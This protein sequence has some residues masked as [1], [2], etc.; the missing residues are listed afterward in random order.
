M[1]KKKRLKTDRVKKEE[2]GS[3]RQDRGMKAIV[4]PIKPVEDALDMKIEGWQLDQLAQGF[5]W[6]ALKNL[7]LSDPVL[8]ILNPKLM[9]EIQGL[10]SRSKVAANAVEGISA[11]IQLQRDAGAN[12][13][14]KQLP[15]LPM[16]RGGIIPDRHKYASAESEMESDDSVGI[17]RMSLGPSGGTHLRDRVESVKLNSLSK[18][19]GA[20]EQMT[21]TTQGLLQTYLDEA[22]ELFHQD[23]Q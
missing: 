4:K 21:T 6:K 8:R 17:Q 18:A 7:L 2:P 15:R 22:M 14:I 5:Q 23:Q 11:I 20:K 10:I 3:L 1:S 9:G 19:T 13:R 12:P 16:S